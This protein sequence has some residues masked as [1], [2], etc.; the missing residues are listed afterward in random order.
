M[1]DSEE[2]VNDTYMGAWDAIP[3]ARSDNFM[4]FLGKIASIAG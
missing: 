2:C 3:P 1:D 4:A